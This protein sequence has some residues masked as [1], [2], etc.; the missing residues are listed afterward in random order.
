MDARETLSIETEEMRTIVDVTDRIA[1]AVPSGAN[2]TCTVFVEHTTAAITINEAESRLLDDI[3]DVLADLV[4]SEG[5]AHDKLDMNGDAHLRSMLLG[6]SVT[7]PVADGDLAIGSWQ[8]LL[9]VESDGPRTRTV[10]V[11]VQ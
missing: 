8:S 7:V 4:P 2:G 5:W 10:T 1:D 3:E 9:L 6:P 11:T